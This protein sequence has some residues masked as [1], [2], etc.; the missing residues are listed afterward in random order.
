MDAVNLWFRL[1]MMLL[2][3][4]WRHPVH[5]L[6]S[7][8]VRMR[9][10]PLDLDLNRHVTN[11][12]YFTLADVGRMDFVLRSGAHRVALR[13]RAV[14]IVADVWGKFRQELR[15]FQAFEIHTRLLGWDTRWMIMEHR[16]VRAGRVI[17][18]VVMRG[19][20]RSAQGTVD[21]REFARE[22]G[23]EASPP[24]PAWV[25][26]WGRACDGLSGQLRQEEGRRPQD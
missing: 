9:V 11:G 2:R 21:P 4:P 16:F 10:W 3:R 25:A 26:D 23:E 5:G 15:L 1:L 22:M 12:R 13:H 8:V 6:D 18:V 20:F 7:T 14:P 19:T 24:L 17:G